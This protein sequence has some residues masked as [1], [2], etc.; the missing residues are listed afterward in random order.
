MSHFRRDEGPGRVTVQE[1]AAVTGRIQADAGSRD[2]GGGGRDSG[3][4]GS[5][6]GIL[7]GVREAHG[8]EAGHASGR[9]GNGIV[10]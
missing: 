2:G 5:A 4:G 9:G 7:L 8:W 1:A 10:A 6:G 3:G